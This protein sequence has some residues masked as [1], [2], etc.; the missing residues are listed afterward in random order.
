MKNFY[1]FYRKLNANKLFEQEGMPTPPMGGQGG[2]ASPFGDM[3]AAPNDM[4]MPG[5]PSP[6]VNGMEGMP[7]AGSTEMDEPENTSPSGEENVDQP[8][9]MDDATPEGKIMK[10]VTDIESALSDMEEKGSSDLGDRAET[11]ADLIKMIKKN[12]EKGSSGDGEEAEED[13][14]PPIGDPALMMGGGGAAPLG[15]EQ[16]AA[17]MD[18]AGQSDM[19]NQASPQAESTNYGLNVKKKILE[20]V[21]PDAKKNPSSFSPEHSD[22]LKLLFGYRAGQSGS[23]TTRCFGKQ[24]YNPSNFW[25]AVGHPDASN[26][27]LVRITKPRKNY[28]PE[29]HPPEMKYKT[30]EKNLALISKVGPTYRYG[31]PGI[32]PRGATSIPKYL[33]GEDLTADKSV[34]PALEEQPLHDRWEK[35]KD[36][37]FEILS[38]SSEPSLSDLKHRGL[39]TQWSG[40]I[41]DISSEPT[42]PRTE[43]CAQ[44]AAFNRKVIERL[45]T[46]GWIPENYLELHF[47]K[48]PFS[49][50]V[51]NGQSVKKTIWFD[52]KTSGEFD[53]IKKNAEAQRSNLIDE[54]KK[55][56]QE[57]IIDP[58]TG[59]PY[60]SLITIFGKYLPGSSGDYKTRLPDILKALDVMFNPKERELLGSNKITHASIMPVF[61]KIAQD[62]YRDTLTSVVIKDQQTGKMTPDRSKQSAIRSHVAKINL[63]NDR[64]VKLYKE[65]TSITYI[66]NATIVAT[67]DSEF[68]QGFNHPYVEPSSAT[69]PDGNDDAIAT[70]DSLKYRDK[71]AEVEARKKSQEEMKSKLNAIKMVPY[72]LPN[73][74]DEEIK[75][76]INKIPDMS[77]NEKQKYKKILDAKFGNEKDPDKRSEKVYKHR[78]AVRDILIAN[79]G[80]LNKENPP[81][82][83]NEWEYRNRLTN[84]LSDDDAS[85]NI[86]NKLVNVQKNRLKKL[87]DD[88]IEIE[89]QYRSRNESLNSQSVLVEMIRKLQRVNVNDLS[90]PGVLRDYWSIRNQMESVNGELYNVPKNSRVYENALIDLEK[91]LKVGRFTPTNPLDLNF[92]LKA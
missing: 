84:I 51:G 70:D 42:G 17:N 87:R 41:N 2:G 89:S 26:V 36:H 9:G 6:D 18:G 82:E 24:D 19:P 4:A 90:A 65:S 23:N 60:G 49:V 64:I 59:E 63:L 35:R 53:A 14:G 10:A 13:Q 27:R 11:I 47:V 88:K 12:V 74:S 52:K 7:Q 46:C 25:N 81:K 44:A 78:S 45:I 33:H 62:D 29:R 43:S 83:D 67:K 72:E 66:Y 31:F 30:T 55:F 40:Y 37:S 58:K 48:R 69:G 73:F 71:V 77:D 3:G 50:P 79:Y 92:L 16:D 61:L 5:M 86:K 56:L 15:G 38:K 20:T 75:Y 34:A 22:F 91:Q 32:N 76:L 8:E 68:S 1:E 80:G 57:T 54:I 85:I 39:L 21:Q 28:D